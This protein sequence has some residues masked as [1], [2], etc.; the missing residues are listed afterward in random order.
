MPPKPRRRPTNA[1]AELEA[2]LSRGPELPPDEHALQAARWLCEATLHT[3]TLDPDGSIR[4][5]RER[6]I[7]YL[8]R[9]RKTAMEALY[10][11]MRA[12][13]ALSPGI[14]W[15][16]HLLP[17]ARSAATPTRSDRA[18]PP[19]DP[20]GA[21]G[22]RA[23]A[24]GTP[25]PAR[26]SRRSWPRGPRARWQGGAAGAPRSTH[27]LAGTRRG[28]ACAGP[29]DPAEAPRGAARH[30]APDRHQRQVLRLVSHR[31]VRPHLGRCRPCNGHGAPGVDRPSQQRPLR[32]A[33]PPGC[34]RTT[35]ELLR[36]H[37]YR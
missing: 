19:L 31:D 25:R 28:G 32:G 14:L 17:L 7:S 34:L 3:S 16:F 9:E 29:A 1:Y 6:A 2:D 24:A 27:R 8:A 11:E 13:P 21:P 12:E 33:D 22:A 4:A 18:A 36:P 35:R 37:R 26:A 23:P 20:C 30:E 15:A 10:A 5:A